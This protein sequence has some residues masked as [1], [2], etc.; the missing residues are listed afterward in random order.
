MS[1]RPSAVICRMT[2]ARLVRRISGSVNSGRAWKSSSAVQPDADAVR[3]APAP[4]GAL[5]RRRLRDRLDRQPLHL[6]PVAVAGDAGGARVDHVADA[7]HG[8]RGLGDVGGQHDPP[9]GVRREDAVLL[10]GRQ[11]GVERQDLA[12]SRSRARCRRSA[13]AVSRISRSP[14]RKTST[15]PGPARRAARRPRRAIAWVWS[16]SSPVV[17]RRRGRRPAGSAPRPG[18]C[19]RTPRRPARRRSARRTARCRSSPR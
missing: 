12:C 14:E 19:G 7:R 18:R 17:R 3:D 16:R 9:P 4:A 13:S 6:E 15:S 5:V 1:P 2:E 10:G 8:Q 11:P